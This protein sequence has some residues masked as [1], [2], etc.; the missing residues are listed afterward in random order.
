MYGWLLAGTNT[1]GSCRYDVHWQG[2]ILLLSST[3]DTNGSSLWVISGMK[4]PDEGS[5]FQLR[6]EKLSWWRFTI[7]VEKAGG[8]QVNGGRRLLNCSRMEM[9]FSA[10]LPLS[11]P[12]TQSLIKKE[13]CSVGFKRKAGKE[14]WERLN[15]IK[16]IHKGWANQRLIKS[17]D[18]CTKPT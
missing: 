18:T 8:Y 13:I 1:S 12:Y 3:Q 10:D 11:C 5:L 6:K 9:V 14:S 17:T 7:P 16:M 4:Y 2:S 15:W